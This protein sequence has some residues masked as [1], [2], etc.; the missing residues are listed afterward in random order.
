MEDKLFVDRLLK[1]LDA[2]TFIVIHGIQSIDNVHIN[3]RIYKKR[4]K[5]ILIQLTYA[6]LGAFKPLNPRWVPAEYIEIVKT[7][8]SIGFLKYSRIGDIFKY[9][10]NMDKQSIHDD[11]ACMIA[12]TA[13]SHIKLSWD[14]CC[15]CHEHTDCETICGH[16]LCLQCH[17][18]MIDVNNYK[19]PLCRRT[20]PTI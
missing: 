8:K 15:V 16:H 4:A 5:G 2:R 10:E 7:V 12:A 18:T 17:S 14:M 11:V 1:A 9:E 13:T 3:V 6:H 20:L 19:C